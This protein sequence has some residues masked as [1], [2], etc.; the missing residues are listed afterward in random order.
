MQSNES[1]DRIKQEIV[2]FVKLITYLHIYRRSYASSY[3]RLRLFHCYDPEIYL[4]SAE[5]VWLTQ[6]HW[7]R[8]P[9][10]IA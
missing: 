3:L 10:E 7:L 8:L 9:T 4:E 2:D 6:V 5:E 1:L